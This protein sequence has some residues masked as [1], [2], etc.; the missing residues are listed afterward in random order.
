MGASNSRTGNRSSQ[1]RERE[2]RR[3]QRAANNNSTSL[4]QQAQA[5]GN[6]PRAGGYPGAMRFAPHGPHPHLHH[7]MQHHQRPQEPP[8]V[9]APEVQATKTIRNKAALDKASVKC[10]RSD[11]GTCRLLFSVASEVAGVAKVHTRCT[12]TLREGVLTHVVD[13]GAEAEAAFEAAEAETTAV[14]LEAPGAGIAAGAQVEGHTYPVVVSLW[15]KV[16]FADGELDQAALTYYSIGEDRVVTAE[17]AEGDA[18]LTAGELLCELKLERETLWA[19][20]EL[21][22][23]E[24]IYG[25][26]ADDKPP[27]PSGNTAAVPSDLAQLVDD[28]GDNTCVVCM[29]DDKDTMVMPC[30]H[31]CLCFECAQE[32]RKAT[33][34]CPI[35]RTAITGLLKREGAPPPPPPA[36]EEAPSA[37]PPSDGAA[38]ADETPEVVE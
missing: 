15:Y 14:V 23:L 25:M 8:V 16:E 35:C 36:V 3:E 20:K 9:Q 29:T 6:Y 7:H 26:T 10:V 37:A 2:R 38:D 27:S 13:G 34:K 22:L 18:R 11:D 32:L 1:Q 31:M 4:H 17:E 19:G 28:T 24:P 21:Y 12:E 30:R 33:N 5:R